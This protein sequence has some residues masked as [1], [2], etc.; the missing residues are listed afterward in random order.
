L[1]L[2][3]VEDV[4]NVVTSFFENWLKNPLKIALTVGVVIVLVITLVAVL[5]HGYG[6]RQDKRQ[7]KVIDMGMIQRLTKPYQMK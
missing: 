4:G 5:K 3:A 6:L 2:D 1:E 7:P